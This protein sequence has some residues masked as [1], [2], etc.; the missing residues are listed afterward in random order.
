LL[1]SRIAE[2][3]VLRCGQGLDRVT[4]KEKRGNELEGGRL[5][6]GGEYERRRLI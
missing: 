5:I 4:N 2:S 1:K 3:V 6:V